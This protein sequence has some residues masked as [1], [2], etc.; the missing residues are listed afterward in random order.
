M[1]K[2]E[3]KPMFKYKS[4][5][6]LVF[7]YEVDSYDGSLHEA[8]SGPEDYKNVRHIHENL[9]LVWDDGNETPPVIY[10]AEQKPTKP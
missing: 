9:Y 1:K 4:D 5:D 6:R 3:V 7:A 10:V 8:T 2:S